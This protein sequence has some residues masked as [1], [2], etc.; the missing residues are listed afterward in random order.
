[1]QVAVAEV[2]RIQTTLGAVL[3]ET[4]ETKALCG[5][6]GSPEGGCECNTRF[7]G[8]CNGNWRG[9]HYMF[10]MIFGKR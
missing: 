7:D 8:E 4:F 2:V 9:T 3:G 1:M 6:S 10:K 5:D